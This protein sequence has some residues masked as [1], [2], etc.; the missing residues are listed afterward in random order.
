MPTIANSRLPPPKSWDE[1]EDICRD[2]FGE[3]WRNPNLVKHGRQ[4]QR[5]HGVDIYGHDACTA[6]VGIQCKNTV[7]K[8]TS[9][10]VDSE[11]T[12]AENFNPTLKKLYIATTCAADAHIQAHVRSLSQTRTQDGKFGVEIVF[13]D[14]IVQDLS[15]NEALPRKHYPQFFPES[16][17]TP[18]SSPQEVQHASDERSLRTLLNVIDIRTVDEHLQWGAKYVHISVH[19]HLDKI[20]EVV[21]SPTFV[22]R[23]QQLVAVINRLV[24][25][26]TELRVR[27]DPAPYDLNQ[28][29][30]LR[31]N[32]PGDFCRTEEEHELYKAIGVQ[33][34]EVRLAILALC[35]YVQDNHMHI[36]LNA[37]SRAASRLYSP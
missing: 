4:G 18:A 31:F 9:E 25:T 19:E 3:R 26:W 23:D 12:L 36:D 22:I 1:F 17:P 32:M 34:N 13:W 5:Q 27:M 6:Q 14:E 33:I 8:I 35:R 37:T 28:N 29:N 10:I 2:S 16:S 21:A 24:A 20:K 7:G 11:V 15:R 30:Q